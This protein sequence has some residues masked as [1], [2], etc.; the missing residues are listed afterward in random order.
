MSLLQHLEKLRARNKKGLAVLV[1]PDSHSDLKR[2][3]QVA[4]KNKVD[5]F[6]IGGSLLTSD[7]LDDTLK[8]IKSESDIPTYIFP[9][10]SNQI[11]SL[12]DG[13][14]FLSLISGRNPDYLIGQ[15]VNAAPL[16]K[17]A[18]IDV[19]PTGYLLIDGGTQTSVS[20]MSNTT[21][22]PH[23]KGSIAAATALAGEFLGLKLIYMEAGSGAKNC[24]SAEMISKVKEATNIPLIVGGGIRDIESAKAALSSGADFIVVGNHL[25]KQ[26]DFIEALMGVVGEFNL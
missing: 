2:L 16:L 22:I 24:V 15:Q 17:Q 21:P 23:D 4:V 1:D 18:N 25:E 5:T 8:I 11:S 12:A 9:G 7:S 3:V 10:S 13:I 19:I 14:L 26:P 20:Y 6:L